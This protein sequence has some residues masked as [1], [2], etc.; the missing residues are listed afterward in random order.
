ML[1]YFTR[2]RER[3]DKLPLPLVVHKIT[4]DSAGVYGLTDRGLVAPG[5]LADLN[6]IDYDALAL[7]PPAMVYDLP[8]E[9]KRLIQKARGYAAT[10]KRGKVT[11][12]NGEAT[13][14]MPGGLI[15]GGA[16]A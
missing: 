12:E 11:F 7:E 5:Y 9:G 14:E 3:G 2:D 16:L 10:I 8:G 1:A 6:V 15:R 4:Q 13:G